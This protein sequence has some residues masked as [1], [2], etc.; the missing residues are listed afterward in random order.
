VDRDSARLSLPNEIAVG[1]AG[2]NHKSIC[3]FS[4]VDSQKYSPVWRALKNLVDSAFVDSTTCMLGYNSILFHALM[5]SPVLVSANLCDRRSSPPIVCFTVPFERD[6]KFIG[7]G[8]IITEIGRQ[9]K[10]Q[11]RVALA[12][13][14][15]VG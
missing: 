9:F 11:R 5:L 13:I 7:R 10:V 15:G 4:R 2:A 3:R 12:G 14:G 8:D 6:S 1:V